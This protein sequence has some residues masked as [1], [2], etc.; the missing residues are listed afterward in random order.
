VVNQPLDADVISV[1][2]TDV[3]I[4]LHIA[5]QNIRNNNNKRC[6]LKIEILTHAASPRIFVFCG[7]VWLCI[8]KVPKKVLLLYI[9]N[10]I[11]WENSSVLSNSIYC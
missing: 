11:L 1:A 8:K 7:S 3:L 6:N 5:L 10:L 2:F 4:S 9:F